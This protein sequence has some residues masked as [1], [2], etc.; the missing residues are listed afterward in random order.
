MIKESFMQIKLRL[1]KKF[2][3]NLLNSYWKG[4]WKVAVNMYYKFS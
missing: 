4:H 1:K 3:E 2:T